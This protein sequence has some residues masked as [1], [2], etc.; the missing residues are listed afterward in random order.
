[1]SAPAPRGLPN[2][3]NTC[4]LNAAVQVFEAMFGPGALLGPS[5][6]LP[7]ELRRLTGWW[8]G[9]AGGGY[10]PG[11]Q[12][13]AQAMLAALL[14]LRG[15][16]D[17]G[18]TEEFGARCEFVLARQYRCACPHG[19][20][21]H[22]LHRAA[23]RFLILALPEPFRG[24][25]DREWA[26]SDLLRRWVQDVAQPVPTTERCPDQG[27]LEGGEQ[28]LVRPPPRFWLV[29]VQRYSRDHKRQDRILWPLVW[30]DDGWKQTP[31]RLCAGLVHHGGSLQSGHY[32]AVVRTRDGAWWWCNDSQIRRLEDGAAAL[33]VLRDAYV[34]VYERVQ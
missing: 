20:T 5:S 11:H 24:G 19:P 27:P 10:V 25:S 31:F 15:E 29:H 34:A 32:T 23:E 12:D 3:G 8:A 13:D 6:S 9:R 16:E 17:D 26:L 14:E 2:L 7:D 18:A 30:Q 22:I 4:F 28:I 21:T 33:A 1:M